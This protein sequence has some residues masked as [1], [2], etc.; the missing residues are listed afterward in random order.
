VAALGPTNDHGVGF[1]G[2]IKISAG[3]PAE[4]AGRSLIFAKLIDLN[5]SAFPS[6]LA[7]EA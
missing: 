4:V 3:D 1:V 7:P 2:G 6:A 5:P